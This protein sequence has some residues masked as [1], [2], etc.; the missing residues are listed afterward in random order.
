MKP[1]GAIVKHFFS[2][3][4]EDSVASCLLIRH[5]QLLSQELY[6]SVQMLL[7]HLSEWVSEWVSQ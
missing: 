4:E 5:L 2:R 6:I 3:Y 1:S 7:H